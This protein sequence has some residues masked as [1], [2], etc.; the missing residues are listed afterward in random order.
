ME[1]ISFQTQDKGCGFASVRTA[2]AAL[3]KKRRYLYAPEPRIGLQAPTLAEIM[4]YAGDYGLTLAPFRAKSPEEILPNRNFPLLINLLEDGHLHM[5]VLQRKR[6]R[7][8]LLL[9][10]IRGRRVLSGSEL[11]ALFEGSYLSVEGFQEKGEG[12]PKAKPCFNRGHTALAILL[13]LFPA[14]LLLL[15]FVFLNDG[16]SSKSLSFL[17]AAGVAFLLSGLG[18]LHRLYLSREFDAHYSPHLLHPSPKRRQELYLHYHAYKRLRFAS[19]PGG[20]FLVAEVISLVVFF[21]LSDWT[22]GLAIMSASLLIMI[23]FLVEYPFI[24]ARERRVEEAERLFLSENGNTQQIAGDLSRLLHLGATHGDHLCIRDFVLT[25]VMVGLG[26]TFALS[27][28]PFSLTRLIFYVLSLLFIARE[29][30]KTLVFFS[31]SEQRAK[32]E[33][34]F[35]GHFLER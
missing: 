1:N 29:V 11:V 22:L 2:L 3:S 31:K 4:A 32:E 9:D 30:D 24:E 20:V 18:K 6:G 26:I 14:P 5:V 23:D 25:A 27:S 17:M 34:Y 15:G 33:A 21:C 16:S 12:L 28:G 10:P 19:I 13:S 7:R 8:F 35:R